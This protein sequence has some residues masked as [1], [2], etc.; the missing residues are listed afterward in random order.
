MMLTEQLAD[1]RCPCLRSLEKL[2]N[3]SATASVTSQG[4]RFAGDYPATAVM[5]NSCGRQIALLAAAALAASTAGAPVPPTIVRFDVSS[6]VKRGHVVATIKRDE[7]LELRAGLI[8]LT[9]IAGEAFAK[10]SSI[11]GYYDAI[12]ALS[13]D[14]LRYAWAEVILSTHV[15]RAGGKSTAGGAAAAG[16]ASLPPGSEYKEY[17]NEKDDTTCAYCRRVKQRP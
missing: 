17:I 13:R 9:E 12:V 8:P 2:C 16:A 10:A 7:T 4:R 3:L 6:C 11:W 5:A 1:Q 15:P 14:V